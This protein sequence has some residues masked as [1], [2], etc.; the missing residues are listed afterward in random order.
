MWR[1]QLAAFVGLTFVVTPIL[2][3][4]AWLVGYGPGGWRE[5]RNGYMIDDFA[6]T[7]LIC[8][9]VNFIWAFARNTPAHQAGAAVGMVVIHLIAMQY[10]FFFAA[11]MSF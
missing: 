3:V 10:W 5:F 6:W 7:L 4:T 8:G 2:C 1:F 11:A 9:I